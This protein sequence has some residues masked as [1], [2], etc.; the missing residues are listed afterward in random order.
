MI[1]LQLFW[2]YVKSFHQVLCFQRHLSGNFL[3][4]YQILWQIRLF[5]VAKFI[6]PVKNVHPGT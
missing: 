3:T 1:F 5:T 4:S 2:A 6:F